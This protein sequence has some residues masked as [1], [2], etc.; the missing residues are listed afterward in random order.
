ML[1]VIAVVKAQ[2]ITVT[3]KVADEKGAAVAGASVTTKGQTN[4]VSTNADGQFSISVNAPATLLVTAV[5][6][7]PQEVAVTASTMVLNITLAYASNLLGEVTVVGSRSGRSRLN[8]AVPVDV[9]NFKNAAKTL[10]Q[11]DLNQALTY[12]AP[13]FNSN[14]QSSADGTEHIDPA[15]LRGLGPD[16]VLVLINGKRRH[17][18]SLINYQGTVGN[19]SSGTDLNTIPA[20][21]IDRI[22][23]LRDGASAQY[24]SD[25]IAGVINVVLKKNTNQL[26]ANAGAG[27][28]AKGDGATAQVN[29]NKGWDIGKNGGY[30]NLTGDF[31]YRD[32]TNRSQHH[33]LIIYDQSSL[34]NYF[35]YPFASTSPEISR[36]YDDSVISAR[37]LKRDDFNFRIG[38]ARIK[39]ASAFYNLA[40]PFGK[41][42][43]HEFYSF[44]GLSYRNGTGSGFRRLPSEYGNVVLD[45]FPNGFQ[46]STGSN[47]WDRS[48]A[49]GIRLALPAQWKLDISN[50][51]GNNRFDYSVNNTNNA[52]LGSKSPTS[53]DAG[54]HAFTQNT[55]NADIRK[56][57]GNVLAG[58]NL[59]FGA[60][61]RVDAYK[62]IAGEEASWRNY[63]YS[64]DGTTVIDQSLIDDGIAGGSQSFT[65]FSP[66]NASS[67][68]RSNIAGYADAEL[69][70][71][72]NLLVTGA[73][74][75]E[76]YSDFGG[77]LNGKLAARYQFGNR[78]SLRGAISTGFRAPS[79]QQQYFSYSSTDILPSGQVGQSGFFTN[80]SPVAAGLGIPKLKQETA[81]NASAGFTWNPVSSLRITVDG[82]LANISDRIVLTGSFGYDAFGDPVPEVQDLLAPYG[83][84]SARFFVNAIDTRTKG[85]DA[86]VS[87]TLRSG[88]TSK[89]DFTLAANYNHNKVDD[90]LNIPSKL[91]GSEDIYFGQVEKSIIETYTPRVKATFNTAWSVKKLTANLRFTYFGE[92]TRNGYPYGVLQKHSGKLVTD[93]SLSYAFTKILSVTAGANNLLNVY[94][95]KQVYDNSYYGVFKYAPVQMGANGAY[96]FVRVGVQL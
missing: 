91:K 70:I 79:L 82:Y 45:I 9:L 32:F 4:G 47:I 63:A 33:D 13:S 68:S 57:F 50:T 86:V 24:G 42:H 6:F 18:T 75:Y 90:E 55:V 93:L 23:V 26:Q 69:D 67:H 54:A 40:I 30:I 20:A 59:A 89:F 27:I 8:S 66:K 85:I 56:Y 77:T 94:P 60:E 96:Y 46:P 12:L 44:A 39:N 22:E 65:G 28:T 58:L 5:G 51:F 11:Y 19:G 3:G 34:D 49:A 48:V 53:F 36:A 64:A 81:I 52:T 38:D 62:I 2:T 10:P 29:L 84:S 95:D 87:Y 61:Y 25:A 43:Q 41:N 16:Q 88:A 35:A 72:K 15:T 71:T 76:H 14:R 37:G 92:V 7:A 17:S 80:N 74:R 73:V 83:V 1:L 21:A 31:Q 78:F